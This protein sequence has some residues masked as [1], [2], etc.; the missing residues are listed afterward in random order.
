MIFRTAAPCAGDEAR[1]E[2][3]AGGHAAAGDR[4]NAG[5]ELRYWLG[6]LAKNWGLEPRPWR[7]IF[8]FR[9]R[10]P[11]MATDFVTLVLGKRREDGTPAQ[12]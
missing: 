4:A 12:A 6:P 1:T 5:A 8:P 3:G 2:T 7:T 9:E 11:V 10:R